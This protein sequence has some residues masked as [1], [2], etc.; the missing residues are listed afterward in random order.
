MY[1]IKVFKIY[2]GK[3]IGKTTSSYNWQFF[4]LNINSE[5][6]MLRIDRKCKSKKCNWGS[7]IELAGKVSHREHS[8]LEYF[9]LETNTQYIIISLL[10]N[11]GRESLDIGILK[12]RVAKRVLWKNMLNIFIFYFNKDS[13][14]FEELNMN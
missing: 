5:T 1:I 2:A 12:F 4:F 6:T 7:I 8:H 13:Y 14:L 11:R 9:E 3:I 10:P